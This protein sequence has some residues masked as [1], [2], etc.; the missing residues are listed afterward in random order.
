MKNSEKFTLK[1]I[2][3]FS[4]ESGR[5][6]GL[7]SPE[8]QRC[9]SYFRLAC[10]YD[11][12]WNLKRKNKILLLG[13]VE[14]ERF[15]I[16]Y[17]YFSRFRWISNCLKMEGKY[18]LRIWREIFQRRHLKKI[19]SRRFVEF[20]FYG[21]ATCSSSILDQNRTHPESYSRRNPLKSP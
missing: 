19:T 20:D 2:G 21:L 4:C 8:V 13:W 1:I 12:S 15:W 10:V 9:S 16:L 11:S 7:F 17:V 14:H 5:R 6:C 18:F 3:G